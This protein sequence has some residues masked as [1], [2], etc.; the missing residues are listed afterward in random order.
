MFSFSQIPVI[1]ATPS[2]SHCV[3]RRHCDLLVQRQSVMWTAQNLQFVPV[4]LLL[5]PHVVTT[6]ALDDVMMLKTAATCH[7]WNPWWRHDVQNCCYMS[8]PLTSL[9][10][11]WCSELLLH[12]VTTEPLDDVMMFRTA[13]FKTVFLFCSLRI[14]PPFCWLKTL[15]GFKWL[16]DWQR[17]ALLI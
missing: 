2:A 13:A 12:V 8:S 16:T 17:F 6:E 10:T 5:L 14:Q 15:C 4:V 1:C 9:M 11:S 3:F 7:H